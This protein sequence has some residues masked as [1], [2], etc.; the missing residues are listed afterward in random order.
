M[1]DMI[2][3]ARFFDQMTQDK[4]DTAVQT[5]LTRNRDITELW[6]LTRNR[7]GLFADLTKAISSCGATIAGAKLHTG[8]KGQVFNVFY[9]QNTEKLAF[10]RQSQHALETL[11]KRAQRAALGDVKDMVIP[12][13]ISSRRAGAI[14]VKSRVKFVKNESGDV[15]ILEIE[16][17]D[18]P[19]L[20]SD[21]ASIF[22]DNELEVLSAHIEVV[23]TRAIDAFYLCLPGTVDGRARNCALP[24]AV[25]KTLKQQITDLLSPQ[26]SKA[27]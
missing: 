25:R 3:H 21:I 5:R 9:L 2:R 27:A 24:K 15:T 4:L 11:R 8:E 13:P 17:R 12:K 6:V 22:R 19:G 26:I 1:A 20:L 18:R 7:S 14:P 23:G 16:G 10:G